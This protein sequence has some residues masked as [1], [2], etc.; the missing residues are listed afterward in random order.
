MAE[1]VAVTFTAAGIPVVFTVT[2]AIFFMVV[3]LARVSRFKADTRGGVGII[4]IIPPLTTD[5]TGPMRIIVGR[6]TMTKALD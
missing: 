1:A 2:A 3:F 5:T 4:P 6:P